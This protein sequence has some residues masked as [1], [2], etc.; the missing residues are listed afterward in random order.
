MDYKTDD[1]R[2]YEFMS[3]IR[4]YRTADLD[5]LRSHIVQELEERAWVKRLMREEQE[6]QK[7][8]KA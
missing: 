2:I 7:A 8:E 3:K 6:R 5:Y 4:T 1:G